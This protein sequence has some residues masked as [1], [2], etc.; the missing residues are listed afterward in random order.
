[1][2]NPTKPPKS[3]QPQ[4]SGEHEMKNRRENT[5]LKQ[6]TEAGDKET[7]KRRNNVTSRTLSHSCLEL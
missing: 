1:M 3:D 6:L 2:P 4:K 7:N 5:A